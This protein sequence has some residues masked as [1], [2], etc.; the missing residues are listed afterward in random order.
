LRLKSRLWD[1]DATSH[2]IYLYYY[3]IWYIKSIS[4]S[5][6]GVTMYLTEQLPH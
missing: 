3:I 2:I 6:H 4:P 5:C 1:F